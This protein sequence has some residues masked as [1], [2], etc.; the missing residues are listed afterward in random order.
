MISS[1]N[2]KSLKVNLCEWMSELP[3]Q[4]TRQAINT[5]AIPGSHDSSTYS[6]NI[7]SSISPDSP[8]YCMK[9]YLPDYF[10]SRLSYPWSVT[11][12]LSLIEQ[13]Q[14]GI[15]YFDL[16][17]CTK[18]SKLKSLEG[19]DKFYLVHG[20]YARPIGEE[21]QNIREFIQKYSKE[22]IILDINHFY[23]ATSA[24]Q[25]RHFEELVISLIGSFMLPQDKKIPTLDEIWATDYR[26]ICISCHFK[27]YQKL[28]KKFWPSFRIVSFWPRSTDPEYMVYFL[29]A[30]FGPHFCKDPSKFYVYQTVLTP[31]KLFMIM[32]P[33]GSVKRIAEVAAPYIK[34]WINT[35]VRQAGLNGLSIVV[36]DFCSMFYASYCEDIIKVN[37]KTWY[38]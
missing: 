29:N 21:L 35:P 18:K 37:Y 20:Q 31:N 33:F 27:E 11:Q 1:A 7:A 25:L 26:I 36:I 28:N 9:K 32:H 38:S 34:D 6:I 30:H 10:L 15:R 8:L 14:I 3:L 4:I 2:Q 5:L 13:L 12:S 17:I 22:V 24:K 19:S 16:R 23:C